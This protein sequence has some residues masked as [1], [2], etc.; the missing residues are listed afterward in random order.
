MRDAVALPDEAH[1][2]SA[3]ECYIVVGNTSPVASAQMAVRRAIVHAVHVVGTAAQM[4]ENQIG[5]SGKWA[6]IADDDS[7]C[8]QP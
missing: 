5:E 7:W 6:E 3:V 1:K 8:V 4:L 2:V